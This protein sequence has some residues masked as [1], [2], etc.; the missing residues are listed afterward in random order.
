MPHF[1]PIWP[2]LAYLASFLPLRQISNVSV[3]FHLLLPSFGAFWAILGHNALL[4]DMV[5]FSA[6]KHLKPCGKNGEGN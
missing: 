3:S 5:S 4:C 6:I 1:G 2:I